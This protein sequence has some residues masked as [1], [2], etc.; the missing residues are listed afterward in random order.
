MT[1]APRSLALKTHLATMGW[2]SAKFDPMTK[3]Q[4][5]LARSDMGFV[6]QADPKALFRAGIVGEWHLLAQLSTFFEPSIR[7]IFWKR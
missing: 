3:M 4:S 7:A 5:E 2:F 6:M 1:K